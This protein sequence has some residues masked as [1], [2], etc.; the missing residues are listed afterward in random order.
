[1]GSEVPFPFDGSPSKFLLPGIPDGVFG[2]MPL[3]EKW[4]IASRLSSNPDYPGC[5]HGYVT[6][7]AEHWLKA[8]PNVEVYA[9]G[10]TLML[11]AVTRLS[12]KFGLPCKYRWKSLWPAPLAAALVV[13]SK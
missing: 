6:E 3:M 9:C 12:Q 2:S 11:D 5:F 8:L 1:M 13:P 7:L 10:P 4:E